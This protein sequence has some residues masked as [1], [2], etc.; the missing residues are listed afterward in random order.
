MNASRGDSIP[1]ENRGESSEFFSETL[2]EMRQRIRDLE[3]QVQEMRTNDD[4][5]F[6]LHSPTPANG[7]MLVVQR[8]QRRGDRWD[9]DRDRWDGDRERW[10]GDRERWD[11]NRDR[12]NGDRGRWNRGRDW[13]NDYYDWRSRYRSGYHSGLNRSPRHGNSYYRY[14]GRPYY[15]N[16]GRGY[17]YGYDGGGLRFGNFGVWW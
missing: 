11:G 5:S 16:F 8:D 1:N 12:W 2:D 17:G 6:R 3:Q 7:T 14:G 4:V 10:D 13:D 15:G 9:G